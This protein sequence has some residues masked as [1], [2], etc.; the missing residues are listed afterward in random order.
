M[1]SLG[2]YAS[3]IVTS[4]AAVALVVAILVA[5]QAALQRANAELIGAN[6]ELRVQIVERERAEEA[7]RQAQK[8]EAIGHLTGGIAHD[9]NNMLAIIISSLGLL[10]R[11]AARGERDLERYADAAL[12]GGAHA[13]VPT[14][15]ARLDALLPV[16]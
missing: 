2:P 13:R 15:L 1:M 6:A 12:E 3:F 10:K 4:Y 7:L 9:F 5:A 14:G 16:L 11:R 8:M